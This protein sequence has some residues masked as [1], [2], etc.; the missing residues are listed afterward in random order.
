MGYDDR[1]W[2]GDP[3]EDLGRNQMQADAMPTAE[4][5][6][7]MQQQAL[8]DEGCL[9]CDEDDPEKLGRYKAH[10]P[11]CTAIQVPPDPFVV[12]CEE[13]ADA[14]KGVRERALNRARD[15]NGKDWY[16]RTIIAVAFYECENSTFVTEGE[17]S[18]T[19][20]V[21]EEKRPAEDEP[22]N[23]Q[24]IEQR[25]PPTT[26]LTTQCRCGEPLADVVVLEANDD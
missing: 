21:V 24:E 3:E 14:R 17:R 6:K 2:M 18:T 16:D 26:S 10:L 5:A 23:V 4:E 7:R 25:G 11:S 19:T 15:R 13:H 20:Q 9:E 1:Y 22:H 8:A 12:L